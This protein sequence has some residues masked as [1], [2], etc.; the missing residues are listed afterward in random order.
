ML[1]LGQSTAE[2]MAS[3]LSCNSTVHIK[4]KTTDFN[5][6]FLSHLD[7]RGYY[8]T[9]GSWISPVKMEGTQWNKKSSNGKNH[10][11]L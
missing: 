3:V 2:E 5:I 10:K 7:A 1:T 8:I 4:A 9:W 6:N 11:A